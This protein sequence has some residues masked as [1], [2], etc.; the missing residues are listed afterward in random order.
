MNVHA[1]P[2][3]PDEF[4]G[5][6][7]LHALGRIV[8]IFYSIRSWYWRDMVCTG[9]TDGSGRTVRVPLDTSISPAGPFITALD[10]YVDAGGDCP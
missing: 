2:V 9:Q 1:L 8:E 6:H 5:V 4:A 3:D 10:A 7:E